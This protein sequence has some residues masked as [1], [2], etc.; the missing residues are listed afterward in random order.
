VEVS[1]DPR[2]VVGEDVV[3]ET[4]LR[5]TQRLRQEPERWCGESFLIEDDE[6]ASYEEAMRGQ[7]SK[8]WLAAMKS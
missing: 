5:R 1:L 7:D 6:L 2:T 8:N 4:P 3:V